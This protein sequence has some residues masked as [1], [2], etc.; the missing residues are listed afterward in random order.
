MTSRQIHQAAQHPVHLDK[1]QADAVEART[2][3][4]LRLGATFTRMQTLTLQGH[5]RQLRE[6]GKISYGEPFSFLSF[7]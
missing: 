1:A 2:V 7:Y 3:L 5:V 4:D 6:V